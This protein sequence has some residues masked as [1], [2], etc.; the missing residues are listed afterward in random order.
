MSHRGMHQDLHQVESPQGAPENAH[1][2]EAL[3]L[4]LEGLRM[5]VCE[6]G[7]ADQAQSEAHGRQAVPVQDVRKGLLQI[8][9]PVTAHE[10]TPSHVVAF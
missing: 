10:E 9:P 2:R 3:C 7:R 1:W 6:V 8:R 5:E 4:Q